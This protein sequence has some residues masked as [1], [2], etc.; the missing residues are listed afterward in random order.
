MLPLL[1]T[2][3]PL[4]VGAVTVLADRQP[5]VPFG[6]QAIA[7]VH[8]HQIGR[9]P[10]MLGPYSRYGWSHP[11]PTMYALL[12]PLYRL[13]GESSRS[14]PL[15]A[16]FLNAGCVAAIALVIR[17]R[18]GA[19]G[20]WWG[21]LVLAVYLRALGGSV[22]RDSWNPHLPLLPFAL[23]IFLLW[24]ALLGDR[25]AGPVS[26][27]LGSFA[28][29]SHISYLLPMAALAAA[30]AIAAGVR[31]ARDKSSQSPST[32]A[33]HRW[34]VPFALSVLVLVLQWA[35]PLLQQLHNASA[36]NL[37]EL[38]RYFRSSTPHHGYSEGF[39][40]LSTE[41][42]RVPAYLSGTP[43]K[44]ASPAV[45][46]PPVLP[47][48]AG[49]AALFTGLAALSVA[50]RRRMGQ[51]LLLL[52][53]G[54]TLSAASVVAV[55]HV[56]GPLFSYLVRWITVVGMVVWTAV[57]LIAIRAAPNGSARQGVAFW[58]PR[59]STVLRVA[60]AIA[61]LGA[62]TT[63]SAA[64]TVDAVKTIDPWTYHD[65]TVPTLARQTEGWLGTAKGGVLV[66]FA[67]STR[68]DFIGTGGPG[69]ALV[70]ALVKKGYDVR[71]PPSQAGAFGP[72]L[73]RVEGTS[74]TIVVAFADGSSPPPNPD[75]HVVARAGQFLVYG[76]RR[77]AD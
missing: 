71:V 26:V 48:Q 20:M 56:I 36:G 13:T 51:E 69:T 55:H 2:L 49:L 3:V 54:V 63:L 14:L 11:G 9:V 12:A 62:T 72:R 7:E 16:L 37:V 30:C 29:Q 64:S 75:Q 68:R 28:V 18:A 41:V 74:A 47:V 44:G 67:G 76:A 46:L 19:A 57:G 1:V 24:T 58:S 21:L 66:A 8:V 39:K 61:C 73:A 70:L 4:V 35:P 52:W 22:L 34:V 6:D 27:A 10:V 33:G 17:R 42:G 40:W 77:R 15:S 31:R 53:L 45:Q 25:W 65:T 5:Y 59:A 60:L 23:T 43:S 38:Y 32:D 50:V